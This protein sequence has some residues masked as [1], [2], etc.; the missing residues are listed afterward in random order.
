MV[1]FTLPRVDHFEVFH[2]Y[3]RTL[4]RDAGGVPARTAF[5]PAAVKDLLPFV[6]IIERRTPDELHVRLAGSA[7]EQVLGFGTTG[8]NYL[9]VCN[10][11]DA[12]FFKQAFTDMTSVPCGGFFRRDIHMTNGEIYSLTTGCLPFADEEGNM[13]YVIGVVGVGNNLVLT[14][15]APPVLDFSNI[16]AHHYIDVGFGL[17][18]EIPALPPAKVIRPD[19]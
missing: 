6:F 4:A 7:I 3:W 11:A 17:P 1:E 18:D 5:S 14:A 15:Y 10:E 19:M 9:E 12:P 16:T 2:T 13:R 8:K